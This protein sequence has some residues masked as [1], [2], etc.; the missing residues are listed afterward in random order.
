MSFE[1][2][3]SSLI[4]EEPQYSKLAARLLCTFVDKEVHN[5]DIHSFSQSI[6]TGHEHGLISDET[7]AFVDAHS[8]KLNDAIL[9]ERSDRFEYLV[10]M[11]SPSRGLQEYAVANYPDGDPKCDEQY[12]L[13]DVNTSLIKTAQ[14]RTIYLSHDTNLPRRSWR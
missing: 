12:A 6:R 7:A 10:S 14:G 1:T 13:G 4:A 2:R 9:A 3:R 11:S 8:R 5:Q